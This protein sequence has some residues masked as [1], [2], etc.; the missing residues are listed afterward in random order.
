MDELLRK[1]SQQWFL[2]EPAYF[3]LY[4]TLCTEPNKR[5]SCPLRVGKGR[6]EYNPDL[7]QDKTFKEAEQLMRIE[8]IR[9]F[10]K[11]P[12]ERQPDGVE[13]RALALGS[14]VTICDYY[15]QP[16]SREV[17][18]LVAPEIFGLESGQHFE[19]YARH[20]QQ[21]LNDA[22]TDLSDTD[23]RNAIGQS[24]DKAALWEEDDM[25]VQEINDLIKTIATW[26]SIP[27]SLIEQ[28]EASTHGRIDYRQVMRGF[29][30]SIISNKRQLTRM[31]SSR[32]M[33][34]EQMGSMREFST[35]LLVAVDVSGSITS[36]M[37]S[38]FYG[39]I[40]RMFRYG[41]GQ[42]DCVQ[43]DCAMGE[44]RPMRHASHTIEVTGRGGTSYQPVIDYVAANPEYD[45]LIILTDGYAAIP[46]V[47]DRLRTSV[48]WVCQSEDC[49]Q[50]S[51]PWM[52]RIGR[53]CWMTL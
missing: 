12:Y 40:N 8:M 21:L 35:R 11:H 4:C 39:V 14:D 38:H 16:G 10:L 15:N 29:R 2:R 53:V 19:W 37:L 23:V 22:T 44:V 42:I 41:I 6:L 24:A 45:G 31:K 34:F 49:Y 17:L 36:E 26:G 51:L 30:A 50:S 20:I 1:I 3:A 25:R 32:R 18:P 5:M 9:L 7:L 13:P 52:Q 46:K 43:F 47:P 33:G 48:L 27:G 28:I